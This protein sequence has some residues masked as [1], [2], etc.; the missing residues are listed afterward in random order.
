MRYDADLDRYI[1]GPP[2]LEEDEW[3]LKEIMRRRSTYGSREW[4]EKVGYPTTRW[5]RRLWQMEKFLVRERK[6]DDL[7]PAGTP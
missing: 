5:G 6:K 7:L 4:R 1:P 2:P 3:T